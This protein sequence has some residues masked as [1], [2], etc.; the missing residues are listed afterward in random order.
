MGAGR[1]SLWREN[2]KSPNVTAVKKAPKEERA[3]S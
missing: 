1:F 3:E 2:K